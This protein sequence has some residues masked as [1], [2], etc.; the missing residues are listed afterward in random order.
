MRTIKIL[1]ALFCCAVSFPSTAQHTTTLMGDTVECIRIVE[2]NSYLDH[3]DHET[4]YPPEARIEFLLPEKRQILL[5]RKAS[6]TKTTAIENATLTHLDSLMTEI[7]KSRPA[8]AAELGITDKMLKNTLHDKA[9]REIVRRYFYDDLLERVSVEHFDRWLASQYEEYK[10]TNTTLIIADYF[11]EIHVE[12][13]LKNHNKTYIIYRRFSPELPYLFNAHNRFNL[14]T[15]RH[16]C[17]LMPK[18]FDFS[19]RDFQK[20]LIITYIKQLIEPSR[21]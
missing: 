2:S 8:T 18:T 1:A 9:V 14:N 13:V 21:L 3:K 6:R 19:Y 4:V 7:H 11:F 5:E 16:L 15:Y 12:I 17:A 10:D 20:Q